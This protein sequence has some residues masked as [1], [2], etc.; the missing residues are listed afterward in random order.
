MGF[1]VDDCK[2]SPSAVC[3]STAC[4]NNQDALRWSVHL[5]ADLACGATCNS[6]PPH[7]QG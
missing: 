2:D 6:L 3:I 7:V 5:E 1:D 4:A